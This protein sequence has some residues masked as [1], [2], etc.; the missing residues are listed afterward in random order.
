MR[1]TLRKLES[2]ELQPPVLKERFALR[3][4]PNGRFILQQLRNGQVP[5]DPMARNQVFAGRDA[6]NWWTLTKNG[7]MATD[8]S[9]GTYTT[10]GSQNDAFVAY[11]RFAQEFLLIG[12]HVSAHSL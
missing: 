12:P 10:E 6:T 1:A 4:A 9:D 7:V 3:T 2:G 5:W 8:S 11:K